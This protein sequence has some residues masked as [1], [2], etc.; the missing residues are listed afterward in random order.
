MMATSCLSDSSSFLA[1]TGYYCMHE[2]GSTGRI[3]VHCKCFTGSAY[4]CP[5]RISPR[6]SFFSGWLVWVRWESKM[7][8][9]IV[10]LILLGQCNRN[11]VETANNLVPYSA[12][13]IY[14][15]WLLAKKVHITLIIIKSQISTTSQK[16]PFWRNKVW[17]Y[18][19]FQFKPCAMHLLRRN[20]VSLGF[21]FS[22]KSWTPIKRNKTEIDTTPR[23]YWFLR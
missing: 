17:R 5:T 14:W 2:C 4:V 15:I 3:Q 19:R 11:N 23:C 22:K 10:S 18:L 8:S 9:P 6:R 12:E 21:S 16:I 20:K 13:K 7:M 1:C